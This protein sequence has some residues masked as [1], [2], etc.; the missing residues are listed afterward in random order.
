VIDKAVFVSLIV[1]GVRGNRVRNTV[2][3]LPVPHKVAL[4]SGRGHI[5]ASIRH[6]IYT[7]KHHVAIA[8]AYAAVCRIYD[9]F[10]PNIR[11]YR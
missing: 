9:S 7:T 3:R 6:C 5:W 2:N 4:V 11:S 8:H 1:R 10:K